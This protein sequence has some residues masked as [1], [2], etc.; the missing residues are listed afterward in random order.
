MVRCTSTEVQRTIPRLIGPLRRKQRPVP[1]HFRCDAADG[2]W[3]RFQQAD[4]NTNLA[5]KR[6]F[7]SGRLHVRCMMLR[8]TV[9]DPPGSFLPC[10]S[11][12]HWP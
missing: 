11:S 4:E 5:R 10:A 7:R 9:D 12:V 6:M 8:R 2:G 3:V 1:G